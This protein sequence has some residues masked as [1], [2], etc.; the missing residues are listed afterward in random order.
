MG[1][2][3]GRKIV[4]VRRGI[5]I[6]ISE[7]LRNDAHRTRYDVK[8]P[9]QIHP[10][11]FLHLTSPIVD[12]MPPVI[13]KFYTVNCSTTAR[14][15]RTVASNSPSQLFSTESGTLRGGTCEMSGIQSGH[16]SET[17]ITDRI[18]CAEQISGVVVPGAEVENFLSKL[19]QYSEICIK[20][21]QE[22]TRVDD[23]ERTNIAEAKKFFNRIRC[24]CG[25]GT[26]RIGNAVCE[27]EGDCGTG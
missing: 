27:G 15:S 8:T 18:K 17:G 11:T 21:K 19:K 9:S 6:S 14:H 13:A 7:T 20:S 23:W 5:V 25:G 24:D 12:Y 2:S 26:E 4:S 22:V 10:S 16:Q 1:T 3:I